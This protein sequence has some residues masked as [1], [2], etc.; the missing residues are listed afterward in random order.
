MIDRNVLEVEIYPDKAYGL[1]KDPP[2][3]PDTFDT[4]S[5][6]RKDGD[7][8]NLKQNFRVILPADDFSRDA[9]SRLLTENGVQRV[10]KSSSE[11]TLFTI[12][13]LVGVGIPLLL[14]LFL[15][16]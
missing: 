11:P 10:N 5:G 13:L 14:F 4:K 2:K 15:N 9:M 1:F 3:T 6:E 12:Y 16:F 8:E 7:P